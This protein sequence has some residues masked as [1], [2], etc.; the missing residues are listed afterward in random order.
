MTAEAGAAEAAVRNAYH[1]LGVDLV[2]QPSAT[3]PVRMVQPAVRIATAADAARAAAAL[4]VPA[5]VRAFK[6]M[7]KESAIVRQFLT[8]AEWLAIEVRIMGDGTPPIEPPDSIGDLA[9][10]ARWMAGGELFGPVS[11]EARDAYLHMAAEL[12]LLTRRMARGA[13]ANAKVT[14]ITSAR[15]AA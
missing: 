9:R 12:D 2:E 5:D 10:F 14:P 4:K 7:A 11:D 1:L 3:Y 8:T 6:A 15:E 13:R